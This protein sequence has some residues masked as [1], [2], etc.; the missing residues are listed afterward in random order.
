MQYDCM[1]GWMCLIWISSLVL[2]IP[3][4]TQRIMAACCTQQLQRYL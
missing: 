3:A 1:Y 4:I 2:P